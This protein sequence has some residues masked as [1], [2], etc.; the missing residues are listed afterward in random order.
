[1]WPAVQS[2]QYTAEELRL[3]RLKS[4]RQQEAD[5]LQHLE[6][7]RIE[8]YDPQTYETAKT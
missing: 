3:M 2:Q 1:M 7:V 5:L 4:L 8:L 6:A